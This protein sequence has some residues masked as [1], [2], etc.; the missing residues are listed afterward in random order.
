MG[1]TIGQTLKPLPHTDMIF[2]AQG[3]MLI[4]KGTWHLLLTTNVNI[5]EDK[6]FVKQLISEFTSHC[7]KL[8]IKMKND[9]CQIHASNL[10]LRG[11][12]IISMME[13]FGRSRYKRSQGILSKVF[14]FAFGSSLSAEELEDVKEQTKHLQES[15]T[16]IMRSTKKLEQEQMAQE[17]VTNDLQDKY[18]QIV[19]T[20]EDADYIFKRL[21]QDRAEALLF[22]TYTLSQIA[23]QAIYD[24]YVGIR[25]EALPT[26]E[27]FEQLYYNVTNELGHHDQLI[28]GSFLY[29]FQQLFKVNT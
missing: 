4:Q 29:E 3:K 12:S 9:E 14:N 23:L 20:L 11:A 22:K 1:I 19:T 7:G 15:A 28:N 17:K 16:I 10:K 6:A 21:D 27:L 8:G 24:K 26:K 5:K 18:L 13:K 25:E 2:A